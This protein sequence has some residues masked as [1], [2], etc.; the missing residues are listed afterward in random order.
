MPREE[1]G[2]FLFSQKGKNGLNDLFSCWYWIVC[3]IENR[4]DLSQKIR[5]C[6]G[7]SSDHYAINELQMVLNFL[8]RSD[9]SVDLNV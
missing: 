6:I 3:V 5:I 1:K 2:P 4:I 8:D 7:L 9:V